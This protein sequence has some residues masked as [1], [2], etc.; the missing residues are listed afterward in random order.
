MVLKHAISKLFNFF[1]RYLWEF[2]FAGAALVTVAILVA[3]ELGHDYTTD[4]LENIT[5]V[6]EDN[7][8]ALKFISLMLLAEGVHRGYLLTQRETYLEPY[9]ASVAEARALTESLIQRYEKRGDAIGSS[10]LG[11]IAS[12]AGERYEILDMTLKHVANG[13]M[14]QAMKLFNTDTGRAKMRDLRMEVDK[15]LK[16]NRERSDVLR[17]KAGDVSIYSRISVAAVTAINIIL[18]LF[19]FRRLGEAWRAKEKEADILKAQQEWLD[20]QVKERTTQLAD[21]S[22]HLQDVLEAEKVRLARELHDE[23]GSILT[24][25]KMD[26]TWV[27]GRLGRKP[28]EID[29]KLAR[30]LKNIDQGI[31]VK[32]QLIEELRPST[33]SSFGL[34]VAARELAEESASRNQWQL[35]LDLPEAEPDIEPDTA[36]ALYRVLQESLTNATKYAKATKVRVSLVCSV[37]ELNLVIA[38][39]GVGFRVR[40]VSA[41]SLGLVGMRQRVQAR[42]GT[43]EIAS[44]PGQGCTVRVLLTLRR[45]EACTP[46][47]DDADERAAG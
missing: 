47:T 15:L 6:E 34:V 9:R 24:A 27:R 44:T 19:V 46:S 45:N 26:V 18:L 7:R 20:A 39:N 36:T 11:V 41:K 3:S 32:R 37:D 25:A 31:L 38:D 42:G 17:K 30:T 14:D 23:L 21:L 8:D 43:F 2:A 35:D 28:V 12:V 4:A 29:E 13:E 22:V 16:H 10:Q 40:D 1:G 33:L 5:A